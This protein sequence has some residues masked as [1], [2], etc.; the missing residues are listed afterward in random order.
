MNSEI[1]YELPCAYGLL[2][3]SYK[4]TKTLQIFGSNIDIIYHDSAVNYLNTVVFNTENVKKICH[5]LNR[6]SEEDDFE[7]NCDDDVI[8]FRDNKEYHVSNWKELF[9]IVLKEKLF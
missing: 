3:S 1:V 2:I 7:T 8:I 9:D 4:A 6:N 5:S